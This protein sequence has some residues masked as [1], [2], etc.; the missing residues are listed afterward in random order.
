[1]HYVLKS[2]IAQPLVSLGRWLPAASLA[3]AL[4]LGIG[5]P[6]RAQT[7][8]P[9]TDAPVYAVTYLDVST[10]WVVRGA[11]LIKQYLASLETNAR[12]EVHVTLSVAIAVVVVQRELLLTADHLRA[13]ASCEIM[14][15]SWHSV[16]GPYPPF[17]GTLSACQE[18]TGRCRLD[19]AGSYHPPLGLVGAAFDV[20]L[21]HHLAEEA[22]CDLLASM[23]AVFEKLY[24]GRPREAVSSA[25]N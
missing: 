14:D 15:I 11:G 6:A 9:V 8:A 1:M 16:S 2:S 4:G 18:E 22:L 12:G 24:A 20:L 7:A 13:A 25:A 17:K 5:S 10:D 19:L 23:K 3:I 21:G